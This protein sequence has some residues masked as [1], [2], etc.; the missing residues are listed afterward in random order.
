MLFIPGPLQPPPVSDKRADSPPPFFDPSTRPFTGQEL[1][2]SGLDHTGPQSAIDHL[3]RIVADLT[4]RGQ[5]LPDL[6]ITPG[7]YRTAQD[8]LDYATVSLTGPLKASPHPDVLEF[9]RR[10]LDNVNGI[11]ALWHIHHGPDKSRQ[12]AFT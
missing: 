6:E 1:T 5:D 2:V 7:S 12:L 9:V 11:T 10:T 3:K 4:E 8:H